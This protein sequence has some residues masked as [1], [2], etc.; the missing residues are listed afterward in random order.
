MKKMVLVLLVAAAAV[1][2]MSCSTTY[3]KNVSMRGE[4][5]FAAESHG[6]WSRPTEVGYEIMGDV[7]GTAEYSLLFGFIP[8]GDSPAVDF[9]I[10][11][12]L[13]G[14]TN[15]PGVKFA[16]YDACKT[17]GADG[18]YITSVYTESKVNPFIS[19]DKVTVKG[20]AIKL[21]DLGTVDQQRADTVR[22]LGASGGLEKGNL[23]PNVSEG[24][25]FAGISD[26]FSFGF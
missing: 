11:G 4:A 22:Y 25:S 20:K 18:I 24:G 26:I 8:L 6:M 7:E 2:M 14:S 16:A 19:T 23:A 21:V 1:A 3:D 12:L 15:N 17:I 5:S 10:S 13:G 9:S